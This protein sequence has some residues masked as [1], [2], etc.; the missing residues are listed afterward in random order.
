MKPQYGIFR[1]ISG[2]IPRVWDRHTGNPIGFQGLGIKRKAADI[3][4]Y[5]DKIVGKNKEKKVNK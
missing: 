4:L 3:A 5:E 2:V 1:G